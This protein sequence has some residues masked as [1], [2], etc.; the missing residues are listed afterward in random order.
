MTDTKT[1]DPFVGKWSLN[2]DKS[3]FDAHH[4][5]RGGMMVFEPAPDGYVMT[6]EG[7]SEDG[8]TI[9]ERP[10]HFALDG[11]PRPLAGFP[12]LMAVATRPSPNSLHGEVRRRDGSV[13]GEGDYVVAD[14]GRSL[15]ATTTGIDS[16]LRRFQI[17]TV[18]DRI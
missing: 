11:V 2:T 12:E 17:R 9:A 18:W 10:Q 14:D 16:Q 15:T 6:A 7:V 4:N 3:Q 13:V 5:P 8:R 1:L